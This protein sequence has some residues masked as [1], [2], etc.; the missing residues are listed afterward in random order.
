VALLQDLRQLSA[1]GC[2]ATLLRLMTE[3]LMQTLK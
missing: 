3:V 1:P 2:L